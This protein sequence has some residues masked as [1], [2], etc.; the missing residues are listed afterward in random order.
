MPA[1]ASCRASACSNTV[2]S[3]PCRASASAAVSPPIPAP[4]ISTRSEVTSASGS[5]ISGRLHV[6]KRAFRRAGRMR[7]EG[8]VETIECRAIGADELVVV[9]HVAEDMR[10]VEWRQRADAHE[11]PGADL[12]HGDAGV[13]VEMGYDPVRHGIAFGFRDFELMSVGTIAVNRSDS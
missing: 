12:D 8:R 5:A 9:P 3:M 11:L 4:A 10:V 6:G 1:P 2:T 13:I 7:V